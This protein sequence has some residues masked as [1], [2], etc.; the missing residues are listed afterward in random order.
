MTGGDLPDEALISASDARR[1][2][3]GGISP[4]TEWRWSRD[5]TDFPVPVT[6]RSRKYYRVSDVRAFNAAREIA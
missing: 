4:T 6:I 2:W 1:I 3:W 5:F